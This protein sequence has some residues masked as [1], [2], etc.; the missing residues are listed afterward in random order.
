M[1]RI[2]VAGLFAVSLASA[3]LVNAPQ[4]STP[5]LAGFMPPGALLYL[6][7]SDFASLMRDWQNSREKQ[8]WLRGDN[9]QVFSRSRLFQRLQQAQA[10][11]AA[12]AGLAPDMSLVDALAGGESA[13]ALYD[14]GNLQFLYITRMPRAQAMQSVL[15]QKRGNYEPR[16]AA[17]LP[18]FVR[19]DQQSQRVV[20][21]ATTSEY[22]LLATRE[23][24]LAGAL[25]LMAEKNGQT[26]PGTKPADLCLKDEHWF[27]ESID[28]AQARSPAGPASDLRLILNMSALVRSPYFRSYW[29]QGNVSELKPYEGVI[30]DLYRSPIEIRE[31]RVFLRSSQFIPANAAAG[32][33]TDRSEAAPTPEVDLGDLLRLVPDDAGLY[34][35]W[36]SPRLEQAVDLLERKVLAP[37]PEATVNPTVAPTVGLLATGPGSEGDLETHIDQA[38]IP[39]TSGQFV[40]GPLSKLLESNGL[41]AMLHLQSSRELADQ[42]LVGTVAAVVLVG[43]SDWDGGG[44]RQALQAAVQSLLTTSAL[45]V[46]WVERKSGA[47][48]FYQGDGLSTVVMATRGRYLVVANDA[49]LLGAVLAG[50]SNPRGAVNGVY[51][52]GFR[53]ALES[54]NFTRMTRLIDYADRQTLVQRGGP[55]VV[56][57][58]PFFSGNVASLNRTLATIGSMSIVVKDDGSSISQ[59]VVYRLAR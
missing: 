3:A 24:V 8:L 32:E 10:E 2:F 43:A 1:K 19:V 9:Y 20:A 57:E 41:R 15:A 53:Q 58:P 56:A 38:P 17:G 26:N 4:S 29:I 54:E 36:I 18:Y 35:A 50:I 16:S 12:A 23:D 21:F 28:A 59:T 55:G 33:A 49:R 48:T 6:E 5:P 22:L 13:L 7:A 34:R 42:V 45:G 40:P 30:S 47:N 51:A 52:A 14:I 25:S 11:F 46:N 31:E 27:T 37:R 44:A 39:S